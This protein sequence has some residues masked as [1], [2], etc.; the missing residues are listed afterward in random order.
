[1]IDYIIYSEFDI[2]KGNVV[3]IEYPIKT[4]ITEMTLSLNMSLKEYILY[5]EWYILYYINY[6]YL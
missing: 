1:M 2:K 6:L 3:K 5:N 4:R